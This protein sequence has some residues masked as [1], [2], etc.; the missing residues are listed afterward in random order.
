MRRSLRGSRGRSFSSSYRRLGGGGGGG[1]FSSGGVCGCGGVSGFGCVGVG[2]PR[3]VYILMSEG[4][5]QGS[6]LS[7]IGSSGGL[8]PVTCNVTVTLGSLTVAVTRAV[9]KVLTSCLKGSTTGM[10]NRMPGGR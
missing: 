6:N 5:G 2:G 7:L 9:V 8:Q 10:W 1:G 4:A 3:L